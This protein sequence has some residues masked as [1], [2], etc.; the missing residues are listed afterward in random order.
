ML[1]SV[2]LH[3]TSILEQFQVGISS[4]ILIKHNFFIKDNYDVVED[5]LIQI[6]L[7]PEVSC[8]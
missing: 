8:V 2:L 7:S 4:D 1:Q 5:Y 6:Y 3:R